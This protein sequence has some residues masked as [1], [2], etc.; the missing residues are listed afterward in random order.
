MRLNETWLNT[1][2]LGTGQPIRDCHECP[3]A[4]QCGTLDFLDASRCP[5]QGCNTTCLVSDI[6]DIPENN[7]QCYQ[8]FCAPPDTD[9]FTVDPHRVELEGVLYLNRSGSQVELWEIDVF[10]RADDCSRP[11]IFDEVSSLKKKFKTS[12]NS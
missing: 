11:S 9:F 10:C 2:V 3:D 8:S 5:V 6:F 12:T 7:L 4:P 1:N